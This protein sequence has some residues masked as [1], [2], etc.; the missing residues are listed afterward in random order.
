MKTVLQI[1]GIIIVVAGFAL[2]VIFDLDQD[3][4]IIVL[5]FGVTVAA[6]FVDAADSA[7]KKWKS[8]LTDGIIFLGALT[9]TI[10][11][12][13]K[14]NIIAIAGAVVTVCAVLV[15]L[16]ISKISSSDS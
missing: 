7:T 15:P 16:I 6:S 1:I 4:L 8:Y 10:G 11:G 14:T 5:G 12:M 9:A 3:H 2:G 13:T